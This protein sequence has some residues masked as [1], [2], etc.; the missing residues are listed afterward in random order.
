[1]RLTEITSEPILEMIPT[2][3]GPGK[4]TELKVIKQ[5]PRQTTL[6]DPN[7]KVKTVVPNDPKK[8]GMIQKDQ[9]GKAV[10]NTKAQG[11]VPVVK[12]GQTVTVKQ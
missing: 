10:L 6:Q 8:P 11:P 3:T 7:T 2:T 5:E 12:P 4:D 9:T 1:M